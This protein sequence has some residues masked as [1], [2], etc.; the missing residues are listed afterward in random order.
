MG[1][2]DEIFNTKPA[3]TTPAAPTPAAGGAFGSIFAS[4]P[5]ATA[6]AVPTTQPPVTAK[7]PTT[8]P[9]SVIPRPPALPAVAPTPSIPPGPTQTPPAPSKGLFS[10]FLSSLATGAKNLE[11]KGAAAISGFNDF[12]TGKKQAPPPVDV[13]AMSEK[14]L[15]DLMAGRDTGSITQGK[16]PKLPGED[17]PVIGTG[18]KATKAAYDVAADTINDTASRATDLFYTLGGIKTE[19]GKP[20]L[21][22]KFGETGEPYYQSALTVTDGD[23][24]HKADPSQIVA[25]RITKM[26]S[27]A[28]GGLNVAF[29]PASAGIKAAEQ[30]PVVK[31]LAFGVDYIF[32]KAGELGGWEAKTIV[33]ALPISDEAKAK[34]MPLATELAGL[35]N[36]IALGKVAHDTVTDVHTRFQDLHDSIAEKTDQGL[37]LTQAEKAYQKIADV[38]EQIKNQIVDSVKNIKNIPNQQ[39]GFAKIPF[40][41]GEDKPVDNSAIDTTSQKQTQPPENVHGPITGEKINE[42]FTAFHP[43]SQTLGI[44]RDEMPQ[45][46]AEHRGALTQFL[47]GK[48]IAHE[49]TEIK[50]TELKPSQAE[51]SPAKVEKALNYEGGDR[52]ILVSSDNHVLDGHH[53]WVAA[54]ASDP[55]API[56]IIKF[57]KPASEII[58]HIKEFP[59]QEGAKPVE[60]AA[61]ETAKPVPSTKVEP[62]K[63]PYFTPEKIEFLQKALDDRQKQLVDEAAYKEKHARLVKEANR[64]TLGAKDSLYKKLQ[65]SLNP[66]KFLD[67]TTRDSFREWKRSLLVGKEI[68]NEDTHSVN[69]PA[70]EGMK[71]INDYEAARP[72]KYSAQL[73]TIFDSLHKEATARGLDFGFRENYL[74]HVYKETPV[75]IREAFAKFLKD[76]GVDD[77]MA[78]DYLDGVTELTPELAKSLKLN[79]SFIK[80]RTFNSYA[81][82]EKYGLHPKYDNP[83]QLVGYYRQELEKTMANRTFMDKLQK[84][85]KILPA[86]L[87]PR[88]WDEIKLVYGGDRWFAPK[89]FAKVINGQILNEQ[90]LGFLDKAFHMTAEASKKMQEIALSAGVPKSNINFFSIGQTIKAITAGDFKSV[91]P[92]LRANFNEASIRYFEKNQGVIKDMAAQGIDIGKRVGSYGELYGQL[93]KKWGERD[94]KGIAGEAWD[95]LFNEKTFGSFMPQLYMQTFKDAVA[96]GMKSGLEK[97]EANEFAADV[98]RK[99]F[100]LFEDAGRSLK[101]QDKLSASLFA[102]KFREGI[103]NTLFNTV[104]SVT[105][106]IRNPAFYK[107][108]RLVAGMAITYAAYNALNYKLNGNFMWSNPNGHEFDLRIP[109]D[110][111]EVVYMPF[112]PSFL[113]FGRNLVSGVLNVGK[114]DFKTAGQQFSGVLSM[115]FQIG[116]QVL[117][118]KNY[119]GNPIYADTDTTSTKLLKIAKY[120]GLAVN[121]PYVAEL[122]N[123]ISDK[124]PLYQ[125]I[126]TALE[127]PLKF[128]SQTKEQQ[129]QFYDAL[130]KQRLDQARANDAFLP[131]FTQIQGLIKAGKNDEAQSQLDNLSDSDYEIYKNMKAAETRGGTI[132][133]QQAFLPTYNVIRTKVLSGDLQGAQAQLDG[134]SDDEYKFYSQLNTKFKGAKTDSTGTPKTQDLGPGSLASGTYDQQSFLTHIVNGAKALGTD[135][136]T[137]FNREFTGEKIVR[138]DNGTIY[139]ERLPLK[140]S[141]AIKEKGNGNN[142]DMKLDHTVPLE[143]GGSNALSNLKLVPTATWASY[144]PVENMLGAALRSGTINNKAAQSMI[145]RFKNGEITADDVSAE[146]NGAQS[147]TGGP[148]STLGSFFG[149]NKAM[150]AELTPA[151]QKAQAAKKAPVLPALTTNTAKTNVAFRETGSVKGDKYAYSRKNTDGT[152]DL[153]KYQTNERTLASYA[154]Q[155]LGRPVSNKE[156]LANPDLQE[157]FFDEEYKHLSALGVKNLDTFLALHT[158]GWGDISAKRVAE[159]KAQPRIKGYIANVPTS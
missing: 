149:V 26:I 116:S 74:P 18:I 105:T 3:S 20:V 119:F 91:V 23:Y 6:P 135:P 133:S 112:M 63:K 97:P 81:E 144:T 58:D 50:P 43:D 118:N 32:G 37:P 106:E 85:G 115:P 62:T 142:P 16:A 28:S 155:F 117:T 54:L 151:Q 47:G 11:Q 86:D 17:I 126:S 45:V 150:A 56:K 27:L 19:G 67:S 96:R 156:F 53:Q 159:L 59:S 107:N 98:T 145:T 137:F 73:K 113:A 64:P 130:D 52:S 40:V 36:Q 104:K 120:V 128:S 92:F 29:L 125:S 21:N 121:H 111:G 75:Q 136:I 9:A 143:L 148:V 109:R 33:G 44:P 66:V 42:E 88:T 55:E 108:R 5:A 154:K 7:V 49:S 89:E 12:V 124:K 157:K 65:K 158:A 132:K 2:F 46:K 57:D 10:S 70:K 51:F 14:T 152:L 90:D 103:L 41:S 140:E 147:K 1:A 60:Q 72:T 78:K 82:A 95:K 129:A 30:V 31:N 35:L 110:N 87:A 99:M 76:K 127:L 4:A 101:T 131:V 34:I 134:L 13:K 8:T 141:Q 22:P 77:Q 93:A 123:Q 69:I 83:A 100:G 39:G 102:P 24:T 38:R 79:P 48:D 122:M 71:V 139:V 114:G 153:G 61:Q 80:Q 25:D 15:S 94:F 138:V 84:E 146:I 68:A